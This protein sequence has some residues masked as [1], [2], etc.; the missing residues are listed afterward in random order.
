VV[1]VRPEIDRAEQ[2]H[3]M[4]TLTPLDVLG[5][6]LVYGLPLGTAATHPKRFRKQAIVDGQIVGTPTSYT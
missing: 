5:Q 1:P 2:L 6:S 3:E 4:P